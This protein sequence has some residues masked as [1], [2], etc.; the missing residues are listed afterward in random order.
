MFGSTLDRPVPSELHDR[1]LTVLSEE[2]ADE[3]TTRGRVSAPRG[4][5]IAVAASISLAVL[6]SAFGLIQVERAREEARDAASFRTVLATLGGTSRPIEL[7]DHMIASVRRMI[8]EIP[9]TD[10]A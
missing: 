5:R 6:A 9:A 3:K 2:W 10:R 1:V 4:W 7:V 8:D